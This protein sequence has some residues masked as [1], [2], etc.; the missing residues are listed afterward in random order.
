M[1]TISAFANDGKVVQDIKEALATNE[2]FK[3]REEHHGLQRNLGF[4]N[5]LEGWLA[6]SDAYEENENQAPGV[7]LLCITPAFFKRAV[8]LR[9]TVLV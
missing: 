7:P 8:A 2:I 5:F 3:T 9:T 4:S 6:P 1:Q